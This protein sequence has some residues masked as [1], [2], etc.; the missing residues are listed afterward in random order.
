VNKRKKGGKERKGK[1]SQRRT[2]GSEDEIV[3]KTKE[4][5]NRKKIMTKWFPIS[6]SKYL[7]Y[8]AAGAEVN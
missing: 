5:W 2:K 8:T 4:V 6:S 7:N 1:E 3:P